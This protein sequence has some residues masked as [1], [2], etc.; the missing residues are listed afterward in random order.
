MPFKFEKL[1]VWHKALELAGMISDLTKSFPKEELFILTAQMKRAA[2]STV[3]NIAE[4][5]TL[6][7]DQEF[8]RFLVIANRSAIEVVS[9]LYLA[10]QRSFLSEENFTRLYMFYEEL[11]VM[12]QALIKSLSQ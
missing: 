5:S 3:L 10:K 6:Q 2:D 7:S 11:I 12:I 8:K 1:K 4:G 9:C